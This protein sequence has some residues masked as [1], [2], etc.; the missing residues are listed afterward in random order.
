M[1]EKHPNPRNMNILGF[2]LI[3][4]FVIEVVIDFVRLV[5]HWF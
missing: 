3:L 5:F 1:K 4:E 2:F